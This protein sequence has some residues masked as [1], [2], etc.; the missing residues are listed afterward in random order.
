MPK[1]GARVKTSPS[2]YFA[3]SGISKR[4]V[5]RAFGVKFSKSTCALPDQFTP[6]QLACLRPIACSSVPV[7]PLANDSSAGSNP[8]A[9]R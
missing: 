7:V 5:I 6:Q 9:S 4:S 3:L 1:L 2:V 8:S